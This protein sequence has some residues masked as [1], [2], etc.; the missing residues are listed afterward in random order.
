MKNLETLFTQSEIST[1]KRFVA[2][3]AES[4][5]ENQSEFSIGETDDEVKA[6]VKEWLRRRYLKGHG[7]RKNN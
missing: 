3:V 7:K 6:E 4:N 1:I 2:F 5:E